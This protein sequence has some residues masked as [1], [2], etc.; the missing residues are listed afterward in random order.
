MRAGVV[1]HQQGPALGREVLEA[2]PLGPEPVS[3]D[4]VVDLAGQRP[5]S[6]AAAPLVDVASAGVGEGI[7]RCRRPAERHQG[8]TGRGLGA[9]GLRRRLG[10]GPAGGLDLVVALG[11]SPH[12]RCASRRG[13]PVEVT[14]DSLGDSQTSVPVT[15]SLVVASPAME[16]PNF[17]RTVV[18]LLAAGSAEGALGVVLN[19]PNEVPVGALLPGWDEFAAE[20]GSV[21]VGGP[22]SRDSVI[23]LAHLRPGIDA[24]ISRLFAGAR[25][26]GPGHHRSPPLAGRDGGGR[27]RGAAV[28]RLRGLVARPVGGRDRGRRVAHRSRS[29]RRRVLDRARRLVARRS[30]ADRVG[31]TPCTPTLR[32]S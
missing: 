16:D 15:G 27:A 6:L 12:P 1:G 2:L 10:A 23:C 30:C 25:C 29:H 14:S 4:G 21:F 3:V 9:R 11:H 18:L 26:R 24:G 19:R 5:H 28:L 22:V 13:R 8:A 31:C 17:E 20:P 32:R 7:A